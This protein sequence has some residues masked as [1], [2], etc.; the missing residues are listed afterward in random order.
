MYSMAIAAAALGG[1]IDKAFYGFDMWVYH[2]FGSLQNG[3]F[4]QL[5]KIFTAFGDEGFVIPVAVFGLILCFFKK[6]RKYGFALVFAIMIGTLVTNIVVKPAVLR[7]RPYNTLQN[8][9]IWNEYKVWYETAGAFSESDYSFPSG[10]TTAAFEMAIALFLCFRST[11]KELAAEGKKTVMGK[12]AFVFPIVAICTMGSR[13]YLMVHYP[14]DVLAGLIVGSLAG[15]C[16][17]LISKALCKLFEKTALDKIDLE[18]IS[19]KGFNKKAVTAVILVAVCAMFANSYIPALSE[20]GDAERCAYVGEYD[21]YNEARVD[22]EK[23]Y[24]F[25]GDGDGDL[26]NYCKIHW[27][28]LHGED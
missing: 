1:A 23:Y 15:V 24:A 17:Y 12:I 5:A 9:P 19:K 11:A 10:H 18:K 28:Q 22:D 20:G 6:T 25:D 13:I 4:T 16:G 14:T 7:I 8:M 21:C 27:K 2:I 3:F 26:D